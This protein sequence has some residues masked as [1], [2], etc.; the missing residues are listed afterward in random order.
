MP[1]RKRKMTIAVRRVYI[2]FSG[3]IDLSRTITFRYAPARYRIE[4]SSIAG[5]GWQVKPLAKR[6]DR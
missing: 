3:T 5:R 2:L 4:P 6:I 1:N